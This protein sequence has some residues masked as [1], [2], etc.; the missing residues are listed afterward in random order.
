MKLQQLI[1]PA[2]ASL[3]LSA[4][5]SSGM[6]P[7]GNPVPNNPQPNYPVYPQDNNVYSQQPQN[8]AQQQNPR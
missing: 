3:L 6:N 7:H 2:L 8:P 4:C 1:A 5:V